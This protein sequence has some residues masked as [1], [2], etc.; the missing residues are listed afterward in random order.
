MNKSVVIIIDTVL[1]FIFNVNFYKKLKMKHGY[2][3]MF[4]NLNFL[5]L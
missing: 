1:T 3:K 2:L 5:N 4:F